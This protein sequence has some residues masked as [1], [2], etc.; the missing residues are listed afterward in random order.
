MVYDDH[1]QGNTSTEALEKAK[2]LYRAAMGEG[3]ALGMALTRARTQGDN[4]LNDAPLAQAIAQ[5]TANLQVAASS[6][7]ALKG[8]T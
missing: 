8:G 4:N 6:I 5:H 2:V 7:L 3:I 1:R